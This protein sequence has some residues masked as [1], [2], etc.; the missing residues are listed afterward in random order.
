MK[1]T[2]VFVIFMSNV[3][4]GYAAPIRAK[5]LNENLYRM[6]DVCRDA[7]SSDPTKPLALILLTTHLCDA[8][9]HVCLDTLRT[10]TDQANL[11]VKRNFVVYQSR[12]F[13]FDLD[14]EGRINQ[15]DYS[16]EQEIRDEW[17]KKGVNPE[18]A[19]VNLKSCQVLGRAFVMNY[20][21]VFSP[22]FITRYLA[23]RMLI[24]N[25]P[26]V[27][28]MLGDKAVSPETVAGEV[29][30]IKRLRSMGE[31]EQTRPQTYEALMKASTLAGLQVVGTQLFTRGIS[32]A[33]EFV[34]ALRERF[35]D[36]DLELF[37]TT[38]GRYIP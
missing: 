8:G 27:V 5:V 16:G 29:A 37:I 10:A 34:R 12:F 33:S 25:L 24:V 21:G 28:Q 31:P 22:Q 19:V 18:V 23:L 15:L 11:F 17:N 1:K 20:P 13:S 3:V 4:W 9:T 30:E 2:I 7:R 35:N 32:N 6:Q 26:G 38:S 36:P 14:A